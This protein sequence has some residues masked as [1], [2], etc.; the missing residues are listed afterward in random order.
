MRRR[1]CSSRRNH[2]PDEA[3]FPSHTELTT[4]ILRPVDAIIRPRTR[5]T[6]LLC[7]HAGRHNNNGYIR[8]PETRKLD[9]SGDDGAVGLALVASS[10]LIYRASQGD[11]TSV[12][13]E[14]LESRTR[15]EKKSVCSQMVMNTILFTTA[16]VGIRSARIT[17]TLVTSHKCLDVA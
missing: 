15:K 7:S 3:F 16:V 8:T 1:Y 17:Q 11:S 12:K 14:E 5:P 6:V 2:R 13:H 10:E 9:S 4:T